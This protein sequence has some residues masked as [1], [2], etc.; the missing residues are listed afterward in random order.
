MSQVIQA[1]VENGAV[2]TS[3]R[4]EGHG[5][6]PLIFSAGLKSELASITEEAEGIREVFRR[7]NDKVTEV[8]ID[9]PLVRLD[10]NTP[11]DY[12]KARERYG[13]L[14]DEVC[15]TFLRPPL[16][17]KADDELLAR[18]VRDLKS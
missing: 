8:M 13:G 11:E 16:D 4:Y 3:P 2:I 5:G 15:F 10:L 17:R 14:V 1:H 6:H 9:D 7:H 12:E 18:F